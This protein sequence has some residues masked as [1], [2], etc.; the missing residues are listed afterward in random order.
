VFRKNVIMTLSFFEFKIRNGQPATAT[1]RPPG[2]QL[3]E[4]KKESLDQKRVGSEIQGI[5]E[6]RR[7]TL[8]SPN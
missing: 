3:H 8:V 6:S 5:A 7:F 2:T 1:V 4:G